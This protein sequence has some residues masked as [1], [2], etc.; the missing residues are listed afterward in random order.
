MSEIIN[1]Y[2]VV[3]DV[4]NQIKLFEVYDDS[5]LG[6]L[7]SHILVSGLADNIQVQTVIYDTE[8]CVEEMEAENE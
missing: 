1:V 5:V 3:Y 6:G 2:Y 7:I 4:D 8:E